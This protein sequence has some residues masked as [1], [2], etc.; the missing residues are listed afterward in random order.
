MAF[1]IIRN[2]AVGII[3]LS[4]VSID[5]YRNQRSDYRPSLKVK[6]NEEYKE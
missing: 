5:N 1:Q 6:G 4:Y 2:A 3:H